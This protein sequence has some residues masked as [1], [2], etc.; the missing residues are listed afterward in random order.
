MMASPHPLE[1]TPAVSQFHSIRRLTSATDSC[2]HPDAAAAD[3]RLKIRR[4][5]AESLFFAETLLPLIT[6]ARSRKPAYTRSRRADDHAAEP[7]RPA[8][9]CHRCPEHGPASACSTSV[10]L[11]LFFR[12]VGLTVIRTFRAIQPQRSQRRPCIRQ[13]TYRGSSLAALGRCHHRVADDRI[14]D[15]RINH[16]KVEAPERTLQALEFRQRGRLLCHP[17]PSDWAA[18]APRR[19]PTV[20]DHDPRSN[21]SATSPSRHR[22][23]GQHRGDV[24]VR[25]CADKCTVRW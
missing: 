13:V 12:R 4:S 9:A 20:P 19:V 11:S 22:L 1:R 8:R 16:D 14:K 18:P 3:V 2:F 15:I 6:P 10:T 5:P 25:V 24:Q 17:V 23:P 7:R 21:W